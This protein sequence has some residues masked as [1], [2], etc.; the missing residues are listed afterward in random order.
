MVKTRMTALIALLT[1][2]L[3]AV[4]LNADGR[5][6][7]KIK[8]YIDENGEVVNVYR[9]AGFPPKEL[10]AVNDGIVKGGDPKAT[11]TLSNVPSYTWCYGCTAT[12]AAIMAAYY[13]NFGS[14]T[15][16]TGPANGGVAPQTNTVW[17]TA[18]QPD[19]DQCP[20]AASKN[21]V[22]GRSTR[23]HGDDYWTGYLDEATDPYYGAWAEHNHEVG[24]RAAADFMGTNQWYNWENA[25][26]STSIWSSAGGVYDYTGA[27]GSTPAN[28]DGIHGVRLFYEAIPRT[29]VGTD[30]TFIT[31]DKNFTRTITGYDD[32]DDDPDMGPATGGYEFS[33]YKESIDA[34]R[35][36]FIQVEGHSMI[37]LGYDDS[38]TPPTLYLRDTW[39]TQTSP[40]AHSM[41]WGQTYSNMQHYAISEIVLGTE[42]YWAAPENIFAL[43]NNRNVTVSWDDPSKGTKNM[44]YIVYRDG[45]QIATGV[46]AT[47]YVDSGASDG[48]H[49]WSVKAYYI[50][51]SFTSYMSK[52]AYAYVSIS[53]TSFTDTFENT[54][55][56]QWVMD[57]TTGGWGRDTQYKYAGTYSLSDSPAA[58]YV[59]NTDQ[60]SLG[61]GWVGYKAEVAPGL[62]FSAA[63]DATCTFYLRYLI[64]ESFDYLHFQAC[65]DGITWET[66][67]TWSSEA[68]TA[69]NL[70]T[71]SLGLFA[72]NSNVRFRFILVTDPGYNAAGTNIDN[73]NITPSS[74]DSSAPYVYYTKEKDWYSPVADGFEINTEI[75]DFTGIDYARVLYK[76]NGGSETQANPTS[77]NG[78][79]YFWKLP[80]QNPGD[81]IEFRFDVRDTYSPANQAYKGPYYYVEGLHQKYDYA[82]VS[83]YTE[84]VTTTAQYDQKSYAVQFSSFYDD[85]CGAVV[86]GYDDQSQPDD[87]ENMLINVWADNSGLP[88]AALITP[89]SF[90]NPATLS[91]TNAWGYVDLSGYTAL[92][93][94]AGDYYIGFECGNNLGA[95][96]TVTRTTMT[97]T[98]E[99]GE[100]D[101]G[102]AYIQYYTLAG[103]GLTWE[104]SVGYNHHIRCI[105]TNYGVTPGTIDP[106]P[107]ALSET[108]A[109]DNTSSKTLNVGNSGGF[110]LD[111]T[112]SI[113]YNG[114]AGGGTVDEETFASGTGD[115]TASGTVTWTNAATYDGGN[116]NGSNMVYVLSA[117][118]VG[119]KYG[120]LASQVMDLSSYSAANIS[121]EQKL[122]AGT[123]GIGTCYV[124]ASNDGSN[125]TS[126]YTNNT[127]IGAWGTPDVQNLSVPAQFLTNTARFRFNFTT[128][129]RRGYWAI[130]NAT[131]TGSVPFSWMTLDGGSTTSG[132]VAAAGSDPIT[133]GFNSAGLTDGTYT[134]N[135]RLNSDY[136]NESVFV[137][138]E[139]TSAAPPAAPSLTSPANASNLVDITPYFDWSTVAD[140]TAYNIVVDNNSDYSSPE[141][142]TEVASSNYQ[143]TVNMATGTYYWKVR[144]KNAGGYSSFTGTW[145]VNIQS[146]VATPSVANLAGA[147]LQDAT[148][149]DTFNITND[150]NATLNYTISAEY[151][152]SK[153]DLT[154]LTNDFS[155]G[156]GWTASDYLVW[157]QS[158]DLTY[159]LDGTAYGRLAAD[160]DDDPNGSAAGVLT[161]PVFDGTTSYEVW[162][163][164]DQFSNL[165]TSSCLVDYTIDGTNWINV[166]T[167]TTSI[168]ASGAPDHQRIKLPTTS[169]TM[170]VR[171]RANMKNQSGSHWNI[172]NIVVEGLNPANYGWLSVLPASGSINA[173]AST[174]FTATYDA[175]GM[176][177]G[178]FNANIVIA[179]N[180]Q[181]EPTQYIPVEFVVTSG[182]VIPGVPSNIVTSIVS[183][184]I[185]IQWDD[186]A[187]AE[188]YDIYTSADPYGTYTLLTNVGVSEYTY[189]GTE[190][191]MFF[192]IV[193][194]NSTKDSPENIEV[195]AIKKRTVKDIKLDESGR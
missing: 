158:S 179:S 132:T 19:T 89:L 70:E 116:L 22:D 43:N 48:T 143:E 61:G 74:V 16:Y 35:P 94:L 101:F 60:Y 21:G 177:A 114:I 90:N 180:D 84:V 66:L 156:L 165:L 53:V 102:R 3:L 98:G 93:S 27:E 188:T 131:V 157:A 4:S 69:W 96:S 144:S 81:M 30:T 58:N 37:G 62:N 113:E 191:K 137:E 118:T 87:N 56:G 161:S 138:L 164:F 193:S 29:I 166:Y 128:G 135:I 130:D 92:D 65:D 175:T 181:Y 9:Y 129:R 173:S 41:R 83:Y 75:T 178:T 17:Q 115:Y 110:S 155:A 150:G 59:D 112:A 80:V 141:I 104:Q 119:T 78:S 76:V 182:T 7:Y 168:G 160:P 123:Q 174:Q 162:I 190:S 38:T 13:D 88:G 14:P 120:Y 108:L 1:L 55:A 149:S 12:S 15:I 63:A 45:T 111:Y 95:A 127:A 54:W 40:T 124:E 20:L 134:A 153:A 107:G 103:S 47:S 42:C 57:P 145:S 121:F 82:T 170:Q 68:S 51:D 148:D 122:T 152:T 195:K 109:P 44:S 77:V 18:S 28:R 10:P 167:N 46:T 142:D 23:G 176:D 154:L 125:W 163:D 52:V 185:F 97:Q 50:D 79:S 64:E 11:F 136:S 159:D 171:F 106:S 169:A 25:D 105:T 133:V 85:V 86:R 24:Q 183:G 34:G 72:G 126:I 140:A 151:V 172:D 5:N 99:A 32:P 49:Y 33:M 117:T 91:D 186:A 6:S 36:V 194:K 187:D 8:S 31:V 73:F 192:Q 139:V 67:K 189:T 147:A 184:N 100:F 2:L 26:G 39:D 71:I 146:P